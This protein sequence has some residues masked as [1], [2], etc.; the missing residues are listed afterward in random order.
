MDALGLHITRIDSLQYC[1]AQAQCTKIGSNLGFAVRSC[2][3][4]ESWLTE[5]MLCIELKGIR[6]PLE[7]FFV[8]MKLTYTIP[9]L[10]MMLPAPRALSSAKPAK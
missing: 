6:K 5:G 1:K 10:V 8:V 4:M 9:S 3:D 7:Y 2:R